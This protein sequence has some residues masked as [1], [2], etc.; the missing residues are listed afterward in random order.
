MKKLSILLALL[1]VLV[2]AFAMIACDD[3]TPAPSPDNGGETPAKADI[4]GVTFS[5]ETYTYDGS[6]KQIVVS[7]T[8]PAGVSVA[9]TN[10]KGTNTGTYNATAVLSGEGYNTL[11]LNA[12]L[13]INK[14]QITGIT[15]ESTQSVDGD[16][17]PHL[18]TYSGNLP[19]GVTV[20]YTVDA[21][22]MPNGV[23][24]VGT[25]NFK[26][27]FSG[28]N[29]ETLELPVNFKVEFDALKFASSVVDS[30]GTTPDPW[31][32]LPESF[33]PSYHTVSTLPTYDNFINVSNIPTNG[34]GK[35]MNVAYGLLNKTSVALSY[36]NKVMDSLNGIKNLYT[37]YLDNNPSDTQS[38]SGSIAGFN[39]TLVMNGDAY[40]L[41]AAF[42]SVT[43]ELFSNVTENFYGA[44]VQLTAT[45]VLKYTVTEDALLIAMDI[46]DT[47]TT[48]IE[49]VRN[50]E[51]HMVGMLYE[52]LTVA[53]KE[54]TATSAMIEVDEDYTVVIGT[55]GDFIPTSVSRNCEIYDNETGCLVGT[56]VREDVDGTVF[57][58]YWFPLAEVNGITSIKKVDEM[59]GVNPDTIYINGMTDDTLHTKVMGISFG[60]KKTASRRYDIEYKT[61]YGYTYNADTQEY[62]AVE[63]EIPMIFIQEEVIDTFEE[64]FEDKNEDAL[65]SAGVTLTV[66]SSDLA[67]I[68]YGYEI[69]LPLYDELK[70][71]VTHKMISDYCKQ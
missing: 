55:K 44:K 54:I 38:Y 39:F 31:S 49:F 62:E 58:T 69:L 10:N 30:F 25:Y 60:L 41:S 66:S 57:D 11:T 59:N 40:L 50:D 35:Q 13:T 16:G 14:A 21:K 52:Y 51:G 63:Y 5:G 61:V 26:L 29:Y 43:V 8:L 34:I 6:E 12:T 19:A 42:G 64:D 23:S 32:F 33:A 22:E 1:L 3:E 17:Q 53:G 65:T 15:A 9:Y 7:G 67:A 47:A 27:V 2:M 18:P 56:E 20:K 70:D 4:T 24:A 37:T 28:S 45:T 48:Q 36:V 46:L 71:A 68:D